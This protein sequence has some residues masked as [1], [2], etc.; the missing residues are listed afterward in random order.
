MIRAMVLSI[1]LSIIITGC[2]HTD[3]QQAKSAKA[4]TDTSEK[5]LVTEGWPY[6]TPSSFLERKAL[7]DNGTL[8][9]GMSRADAEAVLGPPTG[10]SADHLDWYHNP[11]HRWHVAAYF[12]A[13]IRD[14]KL[15]DWQT[16]NR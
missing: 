15:Y 7:I 6:G 1:V 14:G 9:D 12:R 10:V 16:G 8:H 4:A 11:D 2:N 13:D 5:V 3:K